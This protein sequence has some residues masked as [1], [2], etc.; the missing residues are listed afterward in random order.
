MALFP[1]RSATALALALMLGAPLAA[2]EAAKAPT[3][4]TAIATVNGEAITLADLVSVRADLP[5]QYQSLPDEAL[6]DGIRQQLV[7]QKLLEQEAE[8]TGLAE[9]PAIARAL[10]LQHQSLLAN[11]YLRR[12]LNEGLTD[13]AVEAAYKE[14]YADAPPVQE[15]RAS[16]ILVATEEEAKKLHDELAAGADF[17]ALAAEHGT[18]GTKTNG[19][20]LGFF[21]RETMVPE[22][23]DAAF[24]L[25]VG[26]LSEPVKS[27]FGWHLIKVTDKRDKPAP[28]IDE[29]RDEIKGALASEIA[30]KV[31]ADLRAGATV[32]Q[33]ENRPGLSALRDDSLVDRP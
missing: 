15:V 14:R 27:Q 11:F 32:D 16:H 5:Q 8:K 22:F 13:A 12:K 19:G 6:Y 21:T 25:E 31:L 3:P 24:A 30:Q 9:D 2:Q 10:A 20:D 33:P 17:A 1:A 26:Q 28:S 29:V 18:D 7:D 23:A 4:D